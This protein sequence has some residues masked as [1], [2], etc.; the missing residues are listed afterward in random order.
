M[1]VKIKKQTIQKPIEII[2]PEKCNNDTFKSTY[3][4]ETTFTL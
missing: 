2:L 3:I 1:K 4:V